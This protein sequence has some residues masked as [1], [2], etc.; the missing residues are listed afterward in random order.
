MLDMVG[1]TLFLTFVGRIGPVALAATAMTFQINTLAFMPMIGFATAVSV[2][3]GR[4]LGSN[5]PDLAARSTWSATFMTMV[6]MFSIAAGYW[7][8]PE[9]FMYPFGAESSP[10]EFAQ[11]KP[12]VITLLGFVAV[13]SLFDTG[14]IIFSAAVKGAGD[15]RFVMVVSVVLSWIILVIPSYI[16]IKIAPNLKGFY[17]AWAAITVYV[18]VLAVVFLLRFLHGKWKEMRVIEAAVPVLR[19]LPPMPTTEV[20]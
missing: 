19:K 1:F 2:L 3:V 18:C 6:Y 11:L 4:Y 17:T 9:F 13:Y 20:D 5:N 10:A 8:A 16:A 14:N 12:L 7:F 15:T